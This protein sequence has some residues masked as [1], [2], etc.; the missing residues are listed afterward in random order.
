MAIEID[1]GIQAPALVYNRVLAVNINIDQS[2]IVD[3]DQPPRYTLRLE[4]R[5]YAVDEKGMR[6]YM[7]KTKIVVI[8]DYFAEA[9]R[10]AQTGDPDLVNAMEAIQ[11]AVRTVLADQTEL[12]GVS[13]V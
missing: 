4:Y 3:D 5:L 13:V 1:N 6:H 10:K 12:D 2:P 8:D 7:P 9:V 11:L